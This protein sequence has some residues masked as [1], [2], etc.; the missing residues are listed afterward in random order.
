MIST[1]IA[2]TV[3]DTPLGPM[4]AGVMD[5]RCCL[6]EFNDPDRLSAQTAALQ[7]VF[8]CPVAPVEQP[9][10]RHLREQLE[11]YFSGRR[12]DF[13]LPLLVQGSEFQQKVWQALLEIPYGERRAYAEIALQIGAPAAARAVGT[14]NGRNRLAIL[15][16]CHRVV[17][18]GGAL[19]GYGGGLW[20]KQWLLDLEKRYN[21]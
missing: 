14:A 21:T 2:T 6:L 13:S 19:G 3:L 7:R 4:I 10:H 15:I 20:R 9:L 1:L 5:N 18:T 8:G 12:R 11:A 16:P 17:N